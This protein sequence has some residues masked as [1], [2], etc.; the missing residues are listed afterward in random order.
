MFNVGDM[1]ELIREPGSIGRVCQVEENGLSVMVE[2]I[3]DKDFDYHSPQE[4]WDFQWIN[5][6]RKVVE[7]G[8]GNVSKGR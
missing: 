6:I 5:K 7:T 3:E 4:D 2:W 1:V 8:T